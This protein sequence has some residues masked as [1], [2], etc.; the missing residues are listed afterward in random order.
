[1]K[2]KLLVSI[3]AVLSLAAISLVAAPKIRANSTASTTQTQKDS[4][5]YIL[6]CEREWTTAENTGDTRKVEQFIAA[7]FVGVDTDGSLYDRAKAIADTRTNSQDYTSNS[8]I[9]AKVRIYAD[10]AVAQGSSGWE[11][12]NDS[13]KKGRYIWTDTWIRRNGAWRLVAAED[14][15]V[16][17][18]SK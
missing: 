13:P 17:D 11:R 9:D 15:I 4:E 14:V 5:R 8:L 10:A 2:T 1:M 6:D 3:F 18:A 7:D 12:R 16:P